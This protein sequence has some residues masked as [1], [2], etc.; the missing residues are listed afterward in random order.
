MISTDVSL[1]R[2]GDRFHRYASE[3]KGHKLLDADRLR[4]ADQMDQF[5]GES[6]RKHAAS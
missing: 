4:W 2:S 6:R 1:N 5:E 3:I